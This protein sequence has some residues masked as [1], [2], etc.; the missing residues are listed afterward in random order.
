MTQDATWTEGYRKTDSSGNALTL[1]YSI[2]L[3]FILVVRLRRWGLMSY[4]AVE[5]NTVFE[6]HCLHLRFFTCDM[7]TVS[8]KKAQ[9]LADIHLLILCL[10]YSEDGI[11][12]F[13]RNVSELLPIYTTSHPRSCCSSKSPLWERISSIILSTLFENC[14]MLI[15]VFCFV[16]GRT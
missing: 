4:T 12:T 6:G 15:R 11:S 1:S 9:N 13:F 16:S 7:Q 5:S 10:A 14:Y 2:S 8:K 3:T